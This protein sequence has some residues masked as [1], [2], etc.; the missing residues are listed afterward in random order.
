M[1]ERWLA[2]LQPALTALG[3]HTEPF[4]QQTILIR[5]VPAVLQARLSANAFLEALQDVIRRSHTPALPEESLS[6]LAAALAC[7][8]AI[9]AGDPLSAEQSGD[10][11]EA[12]KQ[13]HLAYTCPHGRPTFITLSLADIERRFLRLGGS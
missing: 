2:F 8:T 4:G 1:Q 13:Q 7:R 5:A 6:H 10:L 9:R 12:M 3:I 11:L